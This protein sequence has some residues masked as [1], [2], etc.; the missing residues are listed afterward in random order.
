M[1]AVRIYLD[2]L[3]K[4]SRITEEELNRWKKIFKVKNKN[5]IKNYALD[6]EKLVDWIKKLKRSKKYSAILLI[7]Y[8]SGARLSE[9]IRMIQA[10][11]EKKLVCF[12][13]F[14]R[15]AL[16]WSRGRKRCDWIYMPKILPAR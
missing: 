8:Y 13:G 4:I 11:D 3:Y 9:V 12:D 14:C 5:E 15:Y 6:V 10:F 7:L 1:K 16:F 2:Y